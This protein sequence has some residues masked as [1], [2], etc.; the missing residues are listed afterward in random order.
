MNK[1]NRCVFSLVF[2]DHD[3]DFDPKRLTSL[4]SF[5]VSRNPPINEEVSNKKFVDDETDK[6]IFLN[7][8]QTL[9][10]YLTASVAN[11]VYNLTKYN[12]KHER[13]TTIFKPDNSARYL[14]PL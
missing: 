9:Q 8:N 14:L 12:R 4:D 11:K 10:Y 13:N 5:T 2:N 7:F 6:K 1:R 3:N